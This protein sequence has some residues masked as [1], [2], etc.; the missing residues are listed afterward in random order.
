MEQGESLAASWDKALKAYK[1]QSALQKEDFAL[2]EEFSAAFGNTN[3]DG[4][5][6]NCRFFIKRLEEKRKSI[7]LY[8]KDKQ[9]LFYSLGILSGL[10]IG[11]IFM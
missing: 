11:I 9:K 10:F 3:K 4:Q 7:L 6:K 8:Q 2:L 1:K 5:E